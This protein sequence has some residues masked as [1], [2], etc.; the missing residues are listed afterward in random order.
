M[1]TLRALSLPAALWSALVAGLALWWFLDPS[2]Y[3]L[4]GTGSGVNSLTALVPAGTATIILG[5]L[6]L[7]GIAV[8]L[9]LGRLRPATPGRGL[10]LAAGALYAVVFGLLLPDL[11][12]LSPLGYILALTGPVV[13]VVLLV[14]GARRNPRNLLYLAPVVLLAVLGVAF[15]GLGGSVLDLLR[16]VEAGFGR[17][18]PRPLYLALMLAGGVLFALLTWAVARAGAATRTV[19]EQRERR[20]RLQRWGT[21]ATWVAVAGPAPYILIRATWL[22]P[23]PQGLPVPA[24]QLALSIR[25]MGLLLGAAALGGA[26]LTMG[27]VSRWGEV[28]PAWLPVIGGRTVPVLAAVIPGGLVAAVLTASAVSMV[29]LAAESTW[30]L[31]LMIPTPIWG[32]ALALAVYAYYVRRTGTEVQRTAEATAVV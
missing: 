6:G 29:M 1:N 20:E 31:L 25:I 22:T 26:L 21:V 28:F 2:A 23:W 30:L 13:L 3:P 19:Q 27:L 8:A 18:G 4:A 17:I 32:P 11:Q 12:V 24:D 10:A 16:E 7:A 15:A 5:T 14:L 9:L